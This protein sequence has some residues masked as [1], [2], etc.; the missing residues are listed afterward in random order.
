MSKYRVSINFKKEI[1]VIPNPALSI[2]TRNLKTTTSYAG[3]RPNWSQNTG[4]FTDP[5]D[6]GI[7]ET[8]EFPHT[9]NDNF[10]KNKDKN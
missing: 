10:H 4:H 5:G 1:I 7:I 9:I 8:Q 2:R 3:S 6:F